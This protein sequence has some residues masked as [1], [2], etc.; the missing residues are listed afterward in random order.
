MIQCIDGLEGINC[1]QRKSR[2]FWSRA[3]ETRSVH[4]K[5]C[6]RALEICLSCIGKSHLVHWKVDGYIDG[7]IDGYS[8]IGGLSWS[9]RPLHIVEQNLRGMK[10]HNHVWL[11]VV[12][13]IDELER[14]WNEIGTRIIELGTHVDLRVAG[15]ATGKFNNFDAAM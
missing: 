14:H 13:G 4:W 11:M 5:S 9:E 1:T 3:L 6:T 8:Y 10:L 7:Y 12:V 2:I 15:I